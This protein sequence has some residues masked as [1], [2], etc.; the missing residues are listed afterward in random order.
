MMRFTKIA[1]AAAVLAL[2]LGSAPAV[3]AKAHDQG[4]ADGKFC[5]VCTGTETN[6]HQQILELQAAGALDS[7]GVSKLQRDG[8]RG[9]ENN[10]GQKAGGITCSTTGSPLPCP[11]AH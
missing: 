5:P 3:F 11:A 10:D 4:K 8:L 1:V 2:A 9:S 6:S 7:R